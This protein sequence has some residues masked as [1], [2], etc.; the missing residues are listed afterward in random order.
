[1]KPAVKYTLGRLCLFLVCAFLAFGLLPRD[2]NDFLKL[3]V[4]LVAS[5][6]LS[7]VVLRKWRE[8]LAGQYLTGRARRVEEKERLRAAL[9]GEDEPAEPAAEKTTP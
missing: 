6:P 8:E 3:M 7:Y 4:A 2:L 9:A 5:L 1:M